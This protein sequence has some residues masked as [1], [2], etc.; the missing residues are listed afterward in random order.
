MITNVLEHTRTSLNV[1]AALLAV[2]VVF[3]WL[4][5]PAYAIGPTPE[6]TW[7]TNGTVFDTALSPDGKTL[8]IG[9]R[10]TVVR[11]NPAGQPGD[12]VS[13]RNLAAIDVATGTVIRGWRPQVTGDV[14]TTTANVRSVAAANGKVYFGGTFTSVSGTARS[15]VAAVDAT[16]GALDTRLAP[17]ISFSDGTVPVVQAVLAS[18]SKLYVGGNFNTVN[19]QAGNRARLAAFNLSTGALD[20]AWKPRS[21]QIIFDL[22]FASDKA[23]VFIGGRFSNLTGSN[24]VTEP[25]KTIARVDATTGNLDPWAVPDGSIPESQ[26]ATHVLL[27]TP[28]RLYA[29]LGDAGSN[30]ATALRLDNGN[31]GTMLWRYDAVGDVQSL[32]LSPDNKRLIF[33]GHFGLVQLEQRVCGGQYLRGLASLNPDNGRIYCDWL[34]QIE[35]Y[36]NNGGGP[37]SMSISDGSKLWIGG[38]FTGISGVP[39]SNLARFD[40]NAKALNYAKPQ[41][42]LNGF[43]K[44]SGQQRGGL[45]AT[46]YDNQDF[47]GAQVSR[48]DTGINFDWGGSSPDPSMGF[49]NYSARWTGQVEAPVSGQYTFTTTSDDGVRLFV[50]GQQIVDNWTDHGPTDNSG[51]VTLQAGQ[52]YDVRME[53]YENSG[54]AV[55]RLAWEYPGQARQIIPANSLFYSADNVGGLDATYYDNQNFTGAQVSRVEPSINYDW[56]NGSPDP[57][58]GPDTFSAR[59]TGQIEAPV[60]GQYTFTA[61][62][63]DGVRLFVD[64]KLVVDDW[65]DKAPTDVTGTIDLEA[66]ERYDIQYDYYENGGG[67]VARLAW[68]GPPDRSSECTA[69]L[70]RH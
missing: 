44:N 11:E 60:S 35:P 65:S 10:F 63:D 64:G 1:A 41:V 5:S 16:S 3:L 26:Q 9:G 54:G 45:N 18:D 28:T 6:K 23:T 47:T 31:T 42:D 25:R 69:L 38:N 67:A 20:T 21:T 33:G 12:A 51:T 22:A 49:D 58:I 2:V 55:A 40:L 48:I 4:G 13:V 29:G 17:T 62:A 27:P 68:E 34:P 57:A 50:D 19:G 24:G 53:F 56:G 66:G 8:Y 7:N 32:A 43:Q 30:Y 39:Q 61:T 14:G 59:W 37:W 36:R 46:Y 15:N 70:G 52:K